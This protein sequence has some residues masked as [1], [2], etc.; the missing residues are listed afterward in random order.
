MY[1]HA[2]ILSIL[3]AAWIHRHFRAGVVAERADHALEESVVTRASRMRFPR[4]PYVGGR[5]QP[6]S[7]LRAD[8][9]APAILLAMVPT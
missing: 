5:V 3:A 9:R 8:S 1:C 4:R 2:R 7:R 6:R